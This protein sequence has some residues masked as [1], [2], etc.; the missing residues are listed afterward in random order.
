MSILFEF[1]LK[2]SCFDDIC[3][4]M[5]DF[6]ILL[7]CYISLFLKEWLFGMESLGM[8]C[9]GIGDYVVGLLGEEENW[10]FL[11]VVFLLFEGDSRFYFRLGVYRVI[12]YFVLFIFKILKLDF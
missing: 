11:I 9:T 3:N 10:G 12:F 4:Y 2:S 6:C 7:F 5:D 1:Y 8:G